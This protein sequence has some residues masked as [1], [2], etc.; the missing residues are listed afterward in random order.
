MSVS[1]PLA[2]KRKRSG[3]SHASPSSSFM[4]NIHSR[5]DFAARMPPAGLKPTLKPVASRCARTI[6]AM[7]RPTGRVA[8]VGSLPVEVL[9]KSAPA[10][11]DTRL[12]L[13]MLVSV[14]SSPVPR[15]TFMWASPQASRKARTSSYR[16][17]HSPRST[18][19]RVMTM[20]IS[21]AP[22]ATEAWI[23]AR[24]SFMGLSPAGKPV[25][26]A[27]T[28]IPEPSRAFTAVATRPW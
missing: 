4:R 13:A 18:R 1:R 6:R 24:R 23:S 17:S 14:A 26:T 12:A 8:L 7:T 28:G 27:A 25:D 15:M 16:A 3:F 21:L 20:S 22:S 10:C 9:M 19:P 2:P 11:M 5:D